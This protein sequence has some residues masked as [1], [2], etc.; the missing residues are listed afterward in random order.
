MAEKNIMI[1]SHVHIWKRDSLYPFAPGRTPPAFDATA[2]MLIE[3]MKANGVARTVLIQSISYKWDN[4]YLA[5][6][7]KRYPHYFTGVC[8][9]DPEDPSSPDILSSLVLE[10]GFRGVRIS[11]YASAEYD[12]IRGP[13]MPPLWKRCR[14]LAVPMCILTEAPRLPEIEA[15]IGENPELSVVIDHMA[16]IRADRPDQL[17][18]LLKLARYPNV[19]VKISHLWSLT[20]SAYPYDDAMDQVKRL[21]DFFGADRLMWATDWPVSLKTLSYE[22]I[23]PLYRDHLDFLSAEEREMI[24]FKTVQKLWPFGVS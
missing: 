20:D 21:C 18:L 12:W 8:R 15:L 11:P 1:D 7:L 16:D 9:V 17:K 24:L 14:E 22:K 3:L 6:M 23:I 2:E 4:S 19:Y 5:D 13:L 10:H